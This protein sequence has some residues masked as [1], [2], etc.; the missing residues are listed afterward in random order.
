MWL[1][2]KQAPTWCST[3][4]TISTSALSQLSASSDWQGDVNACNI[5][6]AAMTSMQGLVAATTLLI[7]NGIGDHSDF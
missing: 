5:S 2:T 6:R 7:R 4:S 1:C 3:S